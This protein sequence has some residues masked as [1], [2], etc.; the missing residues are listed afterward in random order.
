MGP[1]P[2]CRGHARPGTLPGVDEDERVPIAW[3]DIV[4]AFEAVAV[5]VGA[6]VGEGMAPLEAFV[7]PQPD[8]AG[9]PD[10]E[11]EEP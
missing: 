9:E 10:A 4:D 2:E 1:R 6:R 5:W 7:G 3:N 11:R 8:E